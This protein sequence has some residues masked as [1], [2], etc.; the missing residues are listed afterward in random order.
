MRNSRDYPLPNPNPNPNPNP[1]PNPV[2][3]GVI[4]LGF[5]GAT[6]VRAY[7]AANANLVA[8]CD[9]SANRQR[10]EL[11]GAGNIATDQPPQR[12]FDPAT[13][14][15]DTFLQTDGLEAVSI[16]TPTDTHAHLAQR[17]IDAGK[18]VLIEK[19]IALT[20][21][22]VSAIGKLAWAKGVLAMPAMCM[23]F[24]PAWAAVKQLIDNRSLG[25]LRHLRLERVGA[26][27]TWNNFYAD[28]SRS[29]GALFDLH[30]HDTDYVC[31]AVGI[32][33]QV[34]TVGDTAHMTTIYKA[35]DNQPHAPAVTAT[36][37]WLRSP[38]AA[39]RMRLLAEFDRGIADFELG[40][41][42]DQGG[43]LIVQDADANNITTTTDPRTGWEAQVAAFVDAIA[44]A[45]TE[46]P[47][48]M[49]SAAT[50][51]RVLEAEKQSLQSADWATVNTS[52]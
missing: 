40:R 42:A 49:P 11:P 45:D 39:F 19:P 15:L 35:F 9:Q 26:S 22:E 12:L 8:V 50:S 5:M 36:G 23:R 18:H 34:L 24:W 44:H 10:G 27:P 25:K 37:G 30:V 48:T 13:A 20:S 38:S 46:P 2:G 52:Q 3:V 31:W 14:D 6:H 17:V 41:H 51:T 16:C 21:H 32:P 1:H 29:G 47:A 28:Q 4:G 33:N 43:E 7:Q